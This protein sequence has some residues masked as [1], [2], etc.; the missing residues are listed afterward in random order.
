VGERDLDVVVFGATGVT[1]RTVAAYLA[2]RAPETGA[3]WAAAARDKVKLDR[4]LGEIGVSPP[5]TIVADVGDRES[6]AEMAARARVVLNAVGPYTLHGRPVIEACVAE[7]AHYADL[8]GEIPFVRRIIDDFDAPAA[9]VGVKIVQLCGFECVP[10]DLSVLL[11]A[12]AAAERW[13]EPLTEADLYLTLKLPPGLRLSDRGG[14]A[15]AQTIAAYVGDERS[16]TIRDPAALITDAG[17][18]A[19]VRTRGLISVR[20]RR[21]PDGAV[22]APMFPF[23]FIGPAVIHRTWALM[24]AERGKSGHPIR[25]REGLAMRGSRASVPLR[26]TAAGAMAGTQAAL[27]GVARARPPLKNLVSGALQAIIPSSGFSPPM[28]RQ[29]AWKWGMSLEA[30]TSGGHDVRVAVDS[31]GHV[32]YVATGR[33][34]GEAGLLLAEHGATPKRAGCIT[35]A[36]AL[37][38]ACVERFRRARLR[39][40]VSA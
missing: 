8:T 11:A 27:A 7:G 10:A 23:A 18:A 6:L 15:T 17:T 39:F 29:E 25:Y 36:V 31:E 12:E 28:E 34:M 13:G 4:V 5:E 21:A 14:Y 3:R 32:G 30:R 37:G 1:G 20:P 40:S 38:T 35:P 19:A 26:Y 33:I 9:A 24:A 2:D 22:V 16:S